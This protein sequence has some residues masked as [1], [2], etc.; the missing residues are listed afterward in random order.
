MKINFDKLLHR[1]KK[2]VFKIN[3][4][5]INRIMI[6]H[7]KKNKDF[8]FIQ[9]GSADGKSG[10]PIYSFVVKYQWRGILVEPIPYLY[11]KLK[12]N[13]K[14]QDRL[15]FENVAI[16]SEAGDKN[17]YYIKS[18]NPESE[19]TPWYERLGSLNREHL[20]KHVD[21]IKKRIPGDNLIIRE[22][23]KCHNIDFLLNKYNVQKINLLHIDAEGYDYEIIKMIP[24]HKIKPDMIFYEEKHLGPGDRVLCKN[25]L[26]SNGY[27]LIKSKDAFAYLGDK[28]I[29]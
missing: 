21:K 28:I 25:L 8:F 4:I 7:S 19:S 20:T 12:E 22:K 29:N 15:F 2:V 11:E 16:S 6:A 17:F 18:Q 3:Q 1:L 23:V 13:Y 10:D 24:F 5:R 26:K 14:N 27:K 9:I